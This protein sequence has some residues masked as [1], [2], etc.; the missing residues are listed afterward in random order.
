MDA[1]EN[2]FRI[3]IAEDAAMVRM[4]AAETLQDAGY[5][6]MEAVDGRAAL[7]VLQSDAKIDLLVSDVKMPG[8]NGYQVAEAG[9][10]L[11]PDLKIVLMT[12]YA[13]DPMPAQISHAGI[14]VIYKPFNLDQL[15]QVADAIL[16]SR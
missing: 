5:A 15:T 2:N 6:V 12:G 9:L 16:K 10:Q 4:V 8:L 3:L 13:Q 11:R 1:T 7:E 14:R